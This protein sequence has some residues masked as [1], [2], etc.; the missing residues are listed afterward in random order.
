[1][2]T[3]VCSEIKSMLWGQ[4]LYFIAEL[5]GDGL[6]IPGDLDPLNRRRALSAPRFEP[7]IQCVIVADDE[8]VMNQL[9]NA[10]IPS[11]LRDEL[12]LTIGRAKD[13]SNLYERLGVNGKL[14]LS[15]RP[16]LTIGSLSTSKLY[17]IHDQLYAFTP[18]FLDAR[19]FYLS[20]DPDYMIDN[21]RTHF[22]FI[23]AFWREIGR[24]TLTVLVT[25]SALADQSSANSLLTFFKQLMS[26]TCGGVRVLVA[27]Y[28]DILPT[29]SIERLAFLDSHRRGHFD[30]TVFLK[31][32]S[33]TVI[34]HSHSF[35]ATPMRSGS[36]SPSSHS[37]RGELLS[38]DDFGSDSTM[39]TQSMASQPQVDL[40]GQYTGPPGGQ[41]DRVALAARKRLSLIP[42]SVESTLLPA[43]D[44]CKPARYGQCRHA[45]FRR[46]C[47]DQV[48]TTAV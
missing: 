43:W 10:G 3:R 22:A 39:L 37:G 38:M 29:A 48:E 16:P 4:S 23:R 9:N 1:M 27:N 5:L 31:P 33:G 14:S 28:T 20:L 18:Q 21:I 32:S 8:S 15:G 13:L 12:P 2:Q 26:G 30:Q 46:L 40:L 34:P 17:I 47:A 36:I 41:E 11:E 7:I 35:A 25:S 45:R 42:G 24:P 6:L 44:A 19:S